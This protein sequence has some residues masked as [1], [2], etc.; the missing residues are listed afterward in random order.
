MGSVRAAENGGGGLERLFNDAA[1]IHYSTQRCLNVNERQF[2][3][4]SS[5]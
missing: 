5:V 1:L 3:T 2:A 4:C